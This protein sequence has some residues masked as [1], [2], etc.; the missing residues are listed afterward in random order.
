M[1]KKRTVDMSQSTSGGFYIRYRNEKYRKIQRVYSSHET[2][3]A[4]QT[5]KFKNELFESIGLPL[6]RIKTIRSEYERQIDKMISQIR[7]MR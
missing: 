1:Y 4:A 7:R 2:K 6:F 5:D 3:Q